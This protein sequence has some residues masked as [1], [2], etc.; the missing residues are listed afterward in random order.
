MLCSFICMGSPNIGV[1]YRLTLKPCKIMSPGCK[2]ASNDDSDNSSS[3]GELPINT[4]QSHGYSH[5]I[6]C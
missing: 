4:V 6:Y 2:R 3:E 1:V 5:S